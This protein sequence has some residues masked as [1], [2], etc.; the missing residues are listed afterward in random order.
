[1]QVSDLP[2]S[3]DDVIK[4]KLESEDPIISDK[5]DG[6]EDVIGSSDGVGSQGECQEDLKLSSPI[7][8]TVL[9]SKDDSESRIRLREK[10]LSKLSNFRGLENTLAAFNDVLVNYKLGNLENCVNQSILNADSENRSTARKE[11]LNQL[12]LLKER[13]RLATLKNNS[14]NQSVSTDECENPTTLEMDFENWLIIRKLSQTPNED[15][16]MPQTDSK[17]LPTSPNDLE[18]GSTLPSDADKQLTSSN[19]SDG[20]S[21]SMTLLGNCSTSLKDFEK[22]S[23][24]EQNSGNQSPSN[25][26]LKIKSPSSLVILSSPLNASVIRPES[27]KD[28]DTSRT[29]TDIYITGK[30]T[31]PENKNL[32]PFSPVNSSK[33]SDGVSK[34]LR[35]INNEDLEVASEKEVVEMILNWLEDHSESVDTVIRMLSCVRWSAIQVDY[36]KTELLNHASLRNRLPVFQF[37][38]RVMKYHEY[39]RHFDGLRTFLRPSTGY[40]KCFVYLSGR[41]YNSKLFGVKLQQTGCPV[42]FDLPQ[43]VEPKQRNL[44]RACALNQLCFCHSGCYGSRLFVTGL[45]KDGNEIWMLEVS[46]KVGWRKCANMV[47]GRSY[48]C[49]VIAGT[50]L[51]TCGGVAWKSAPSAKFRNPGVLRSVEVYDILNDSKQSKLSQIVLSRPVSETTCLRYGRWIYLFGGRDARGIVDIVQ[52]ID[53]DEKTCK[54]VPTRMPIPQ[55]D[56]IALLWEKWAI[57]LKDRTCFLYNIIQNTWLVRN[58][59]STGVFYFGAALEDQRIFIFGGTKSFLSEDGERKESDVIESIDVRKV[60]KGDSPCIWNKHGHLPQ[61]CGDLTAF[62]VMNLP[63][64]F[65]KDKSS[66]D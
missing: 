47:I 14:E 40:E 45:G 3:D 11:F 17:N 2:T 18:Y 37:L 42:R 62:A 50:T 54:M 57:L 21:A 27:Q 26:D 41:K 19:D 32:I 20:S 28:L 44:S 23:I 56:S 49:S 52:A 46:S 7:A 22:L 12:A 59:F 51:Y 35:K 4:R 66:L 13:V 16:S 43:L 15:Q 1:M 33:K 61:P 31:T 8:L 29:E 48:H 24:T 9:I 25:K 10:L 55:A 34:L 58:E 63:V 30:E 36:V 6:M 60:I 53:T 64:Q 5:I 39:G 65:R 38:C